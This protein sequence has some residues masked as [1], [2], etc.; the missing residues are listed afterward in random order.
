[1]TF[2]NIHKQTR[3]FGYVGIPLQMYLFFGMAEKV[4]FILFIIKVIGAFLWTWCCEFCTFFLLC[5]HREETFTLA[6]SSS[7]VLR[8][9]AKR[10]LQDTFLRVSV[11]HT[12]LQKE[13]FIESGSYMLE[14]S[15]YVFLTKTAFFVIQ[16]S[17]SM[18]FYKTCIYE[19]NNASFRLPDH[20]V[21]E[22]FYFA[23]VFKLTVR[24]TGI[25]CKKNWQ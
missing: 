4:S 1:M 12:N 22:R 3:Y 19:N 9:V 11:F 14:F 5:S 10:A 2:F 6:Q 21:K 16:K 20:I 8:A 17:Q 15:F 18:N 25:L 24:E 7:R 23:E 13:C